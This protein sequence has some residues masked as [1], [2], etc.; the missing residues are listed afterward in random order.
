MKKKK[1]QI[2][3]RQESIILAKPISSRVF[4]GIALGDQKF[5]SSLVNTI[6]IL[7]DDLERNEFQKGQNRHPISD[8]NG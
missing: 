5:F 4:K 1:D 6:S 8:Q 3:P 7:R 2:S